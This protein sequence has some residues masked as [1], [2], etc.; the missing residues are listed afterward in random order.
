MQPS[1]VSTI[2]RKEACRCTNLAKKKAQ[3]LK[4]LRENSIFKLSPAGTAENGPRHN[5]GQLSAVPT[6]LNHVA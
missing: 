6:G 4:S 3:G 2:Q 1:G 5:P